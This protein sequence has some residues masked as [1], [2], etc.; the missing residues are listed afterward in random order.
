[1]PVVVEH[2]LRAVDSRDERSDRLGVSEPP[3]GD[4]VV[5]EAEE[6]KGT[7]RPLRATGPAC[8]SDRSRYRRAGPS[9]STV[10]A[11]S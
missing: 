9:T 5:A 8:R 10:R 7:Q 2:C 4:S 11:R 1:M 6:V 3:E